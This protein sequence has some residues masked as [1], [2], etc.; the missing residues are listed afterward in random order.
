M[1]M[2]KAQLLQAILDKTVHVRAGIDAEDIDRVI[3]A[4]DE[5]ESLI[6]MYDEK[7]HGGPTTSD[8]AP[9]AA[10]IMQLNADNQRDLKKLMDECNEKVFEA[11]RKIKELQAGKKATVQYHGAASANYGSVFDF[12]Q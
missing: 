12:K 1:E 10:Q 8:S 5:R 6:A 11:R 2:T 7:K 4:L 9:I 3:N